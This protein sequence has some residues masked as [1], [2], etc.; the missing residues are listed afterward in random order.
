[1]PPPTSVSV[2]FSPSAGV[3]VSCTEAVEPDFVIVEPPAEVPETRKS[4]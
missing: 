3:P 2:H 1:M 4:P